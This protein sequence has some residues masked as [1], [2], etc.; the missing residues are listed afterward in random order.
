MIP[1][2][3][4]YAVERSTGLTRRQM[5]AA[6]VGIT[7][8]RPRSGAGSGGRAGCGQAQPAAHAGFA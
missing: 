5:A 2:S 7:A 8:P 4:K 1:A 6:L 3:V